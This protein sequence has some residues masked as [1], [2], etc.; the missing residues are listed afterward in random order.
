MQPWLNIA[1]VII[2]VLTTLFGGGWL[3][4]LM[5]QLNE[6]STGIRALQAGLNQIQ[7][8]ITRE[9]QRN[10]KQDERISDVEEVTGRIDERTVMI[11]RTV[12]EIHDYLMEKK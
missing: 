11:Q 7:T 9:R 5:Q 12:N 4:M 8:D 6:Q 10:D 1:G 3:K 2:A